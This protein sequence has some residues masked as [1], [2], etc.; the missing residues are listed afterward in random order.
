MDKNLK[1][2]AQIQQSDA[3]FASTQYTCKT[4]LKTGETIQ[5]PLPE[6]RYNSGSSGMLAR[7]IARCLYDQQIP[8]KWPA[9]L[10][11]FDGSKP[12]GRFMVNLELSP[13]FSIQYVGGGAR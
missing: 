1:E 5:F 7:D 9:C 8:I 3:V 13:S 4:I 12:L 6:S 10:D 11:L 2:T